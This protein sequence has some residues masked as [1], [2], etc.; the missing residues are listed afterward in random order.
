MWDNIFYILCIFLLQYTHRCYAICILTV[1]REWPMIKIN[2]FIRSSLVVWT[3]DCQC[4]S[5]NCSGFDPIIPRDT[6]PEGQQKKQSWILYI[7]NPKNSLCK[8][9][10]NLFSVLF[11]FGNQSKSLKVLYSSIS[12]ILLLHPGVKCLMLALTTV[13]VEG[14]WRT[15]ERHMTS[16]LSCTTVSMRK[17]S[18]R[19]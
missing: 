10:L 3:S 8:K 4:L 16:T 5:C 19:E 17:Y 9:S 11:I 12:E 7:K 18:C 14:R 6:R 2:F 15:M 1:W 13:L